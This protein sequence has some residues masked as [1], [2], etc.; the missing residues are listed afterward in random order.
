V[1]NEVLDNLLTESLNDLELP[2]V[3]EEVAA[4]ALSAPGREKVL[5]SQPESDPEVV[6]RG[7]SLVSQLMEVVGADGVLGL[8]DLAPMEGMLSRIDNPALILESEEI[9]AVA[10][11]LATCGTVRERLAGLEDRLE[12]LRRQA[13][14]L[15]PL[16]SLKI[17]IEQVFDEHGLVRSSAS[18]G[19]SRIRERTRSVRQRIHK[20]LEGVVRDR[21]LARIVQEDYVTMRNDRYVILLRPEFKGMLD[22]IVHDHSRSGASVYVEPLEVVEQNNEVASLMDEEREEIRAIL[23]GVT[24]EIRAVKEDLLTDYEVLAFL[25][26][27]QA[28]ALYARA[29]SSVS[30]EIVDAGFAIR[31][32]RHPLLL[33]SGM[34]EVVPMDV[35]QDPDTAVTVI[36][37]ANMGGKTVALKIA[38]LFPL[39]ARCGILAPAK[40]GARIRL[41]SRIM[42][43]IGDEQ[44]IRSHV[45][46]FSGHMARIKE[47]V[48]SAGPGDLVLLDE[49]GGA[50]DPDEGSALAMAIIDELTKRQANVVVTTHLTQLKAY[51]LGRSDAK[52]VSVEFHPTTLEPT[53]RLLYD[54]PGESHAIQTAE[55]IGM[56]PAVIA[57]AQRY[58]DAAAGGSTKLLE[59]L[60]A[61]LSAAESLSRDLEAK[62]RALENELSE[63]REGRERVMEETR[64]Q[65]RDTIHKAEK[66]IAELLQSLKEGRVKRGPRPREIL[67]EI[68]S[69]IVEDLGGPLEKEV[70][71]P[72]VGARVKIQ[73][74]GRQGAVK[75]VLD[76]GRVEV[77][78]G[79]VTI[80]TS[81]EDVVSLEDQPAKKS[82]LKKRL[83]GVDI[84][85]A[86]PQWEVNVIGRRA[87]DALPVV[88]KALDSALLGGLSSLRIIHGKGTGRLK[89]AVW[90]YLTE[91][92]LVRSF[93]SGAPREGG[94]GVTVVEIGSDE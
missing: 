68:K 46:S 42:A 44:D 57:A 13:E 71:A 19:L 70:H 47:I 33:A 65:A 89:K 26:A 29:T 81:A 3:L 34:T 91:H 74:L 7:L 27:Y 59:S 14:R 77:S 9:L 53:Y 1:H 18:P 51:A 2:A 86:A 49:L 50:T 75:A 10:D 58:A 83:I 54:L 15:V 8:A 80:L 55:R 43:D 69:R 93:R 36:S 28:R 32:G 73:S 52:N 30:A 84:P 23:K 85:F 64:G 41:F 76:R 79:N 37:G 62:H 66:E 87:E 48:D 17:R 72:P 25:D 67:K 40:E 78:I 92:S 90:D 20:R 24:D 60:R 5:A 12:L 88:E 63:L 6:R 35:V 61:K 45:S 56:A 82:A 39:M 31:G 4:H 16:R 21:D 38:G 22:G 11:M 94:E